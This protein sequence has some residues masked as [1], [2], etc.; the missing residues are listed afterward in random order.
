MS[1]FND[2]FEGQYILDE[3]LKYT[4]MKKLKKTITPEYLAKIDSAEKKK[5]LDKIGI[6]DGGANIENLIFKRMKFGFENSLLGTIRKSKAVCLSKSTEEHEPLLQ[7]LMWSHYSDGLRG[8]C[9]VL[10]SDLMKQ[11]FLKEQHGIRPIEIKYQ[12]EPLT[13]SLDEYVNSIPEFGNYENDFIQRTTN[14]IGTK[15][16][17]W[18]YENE[19]RFLSLGENSLQKYPSDALLEIVLG[20]KMPEDQKKLVIDTARSANPNVEFKIARLKQG[21]YQLEIIDYPTA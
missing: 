17:E 19:Y 13:I 1:D 11:Y 2:P 15:S 12:D 5:A 20:D 8:F 16:T 18:A 4:T 9:M 3:K 21:S 7:R 10:D 14:T 6:T